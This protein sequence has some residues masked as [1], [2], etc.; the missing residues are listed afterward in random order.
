MDMVEIT[1]EK[2]WPIKG[3]S[4]SNMSRHKM[5]KQPK[6]YE[7]ILEKRQFYK[8]LEQRNEGQKKHM[9]LSIH[10]SISWHKIAN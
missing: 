1:E 5:P 3:H 4:D 2:C 10:S 6:K 9:A 8:L 7:S